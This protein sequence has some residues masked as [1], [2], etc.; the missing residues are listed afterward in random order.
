M[1]G[2]QE[3][4]SKLED[5]LERV[6]RNRVLFENRQQV[7]AVQPLKD[8]LPQEE[9]AE[10]TGKEAELLTEKT[11]IAVAEKVEEDFEREFA[12]AEEEVVEI[13][14]EQEAQSPREQSVEIL[15]AEIPASEEPAPSYLTDEVLAAEG[16]DIIGE[17]AEIEVSSEAASP[18]ETEFVRREFVS[19]PQATGAVGVFR[20]EPIKEWTLRAVLERAWKLGLKQ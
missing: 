7:A 3:R 17:P 2:L 16:A 5:L 20:G 19:T 18:G 9:K 15:G 11:A 12:A 6:R 14:V 4:K 13:N 8:E 10:D 1:L